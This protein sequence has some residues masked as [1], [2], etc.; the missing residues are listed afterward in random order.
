[1]SVYTDGAARKKLTA[2]ATFFLL[3]AALH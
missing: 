2:K 3:A 1:M